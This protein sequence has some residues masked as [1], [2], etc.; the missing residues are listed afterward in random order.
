MRNTDSVS[1]RASWSARAW[2]GLRH[3]PA[4][5]LDGEQIELHANIELPDDA[6]AALQAGATGV[7][8]FRSEF[9]FMNRGGELPTEDEQFAAYR[10]AVEGNARHAGDHSHRRRRA[11]TSRSTA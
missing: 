6:P 1:G 3:T 4:V 9:L 10:A 11:L 5:T 2:P 8:L 7:G